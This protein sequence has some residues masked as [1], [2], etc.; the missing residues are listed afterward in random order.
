MPA[1]SARALPPPSTGALGFKH[2][3]VRRSSTPRQLCPPTLWLTIKLLLLWCGGDV[4]GFGGFGPVLVAAQSSPSC[5]VG[6]FL[7]ATNSQCATCP[8]G[9]FCLGGTDPAIACPPGTH[10]VCLLL[11]LIAPT[12]LP[13]VEN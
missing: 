9:V 13:F 7:N 10:S 6:S 3:T 4:G 2:H 8:G 12:R 5:P 1:A 11:L